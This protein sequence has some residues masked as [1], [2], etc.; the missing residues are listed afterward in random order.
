MSVRRKYVKR[1]QLVRRAS[2]RY[3]R[4]LL[5]AL[6]VLVVLGAYLIV[7]FGHAASAPLGVHVVGHNLVDANGRVVRLIGVNRFGHC[8]TG[9]VMHGPVDQSSVDLLKLW[10]I[11]AVRIIMNEDCWLG[12]NGMP[13]GGLSAA[14]LHSQITTYINLLNQNGIYVIFDLHTNAP[15][16]LQSTAQQVMAD[17][18]H[19]IN[20]WSSVA[21]TFKNNPAVILE[22]YNEPHE[23]T[24]D[25]NAP[26]P[27][28]CWR[29]GC[30]VN[31]YN[32]AQGG[33]TYPL[34]W[35]GAGMQQ[36][37]NTIRQAG[38]NNVVTLGGLAY[39]NDLSHFLARDG[40]GKPYLPT[41]P[42]TKYAQPQLAATFHSYRGWG[43][44][45]PDC[46]N[47]QILPVAN[48][49]PVLTDEMGQ[50][51]CGS[52][53]VNPYMNWADAH[54]VSYLAWTWVPGT[55]DPNVKSPA[56]GAWGL[57]KADGVTPNS[58]G[59]NILQHFAS[60][61]TV[62]TPTQPKTPNHSPGSSLSPTPTVSATATPGPGGGG[63]SGSS[64]G[65]TATEV[66]SANN[67]LKPVGIVLGMLALL[68]FA[69]IMYRAK[70]KSR[71][72]LVRPQRPSSL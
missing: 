57:L 17:E 12:I 31:T 58:Y 22:P 30:Q 63:G 41:D 15:G 68:A 43:C 9:V 14:S 7:R 11:N 62:P 46:W 47:N 52:D 55:C 6:V 48:Q 3:G 59:L 36:L 23:T 28:A 50:H 67:K 25:I 18:D 53:F 61:G 51:D 4:W 33:P 16:T 49:M 24:A 72:H 69:A 54:G 66:K 32:T 60:L 71:L 65:K 27:W 42:Q 34:N 10:H 64:G 5:G 39:S 35:Q 20:Y 29:D 44:S 13:G 21:G 40:S 26:D 2:P 19:A 70:L 45:A 38:A 56:A 37:I 8:S 1:K